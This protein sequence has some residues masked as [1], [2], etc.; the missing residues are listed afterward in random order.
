MKFE[1]SGNLLRYLNY[2]REIE[3]EGGTL[4]EG[5]GN[6]VERYP[7]FRRVIQDSKGEIRLIHRFFLNGSQLEP[8]DVHCAVEPGDVVTVLTPIAGG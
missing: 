1:F 6:L 4:V 5:V 7:D 8:G 2:Q 3:V